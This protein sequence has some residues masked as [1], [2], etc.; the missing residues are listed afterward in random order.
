[1]TASHIECKFNNESYISFINARA[2]SPS[3]SKKP[4]LLFP[5]SLFFTP[6]YSR[7]EGDNAMLKLKASVFGLIFSLAL[8]Q[9]VFAAET[10]PAPPVVV[11]HTFTGYSTAGNT[12][13]LDLTVHVVN[14]GDSALSNVTLSFIPKPPF[15][16]GRSTLNVG[17]LTPRQSADFTLHLKAMAI[18]KDR[19]AR[20]LFFTGK[21]DDIN[22]T[23][24]EF[25]VASRPDINE[26]LYLPNFQNEPTLSGFAAPSP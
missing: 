14:P 11:T 17:T 1:M 18:G 3:V 19:I 16:G 13:S 22:G 7:L 9:S 24:I 23:Q 21:Y 8:L 10:A 26:K 12:V 5:T 25:P 6:I 20:R 2:L 15:V 4:Y